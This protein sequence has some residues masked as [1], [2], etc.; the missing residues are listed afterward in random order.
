FYSRA[1][2][3]PDWGAFAAGIIKEI[4]F[5]KD[6]FNEP[7]PGGCAACPPRKGGGRRDFVAFRSCAN[8]IGEANAPAL[9]GGAGGTAAGG[10]LVVPTIFFGGGTPSLMPIQTFAEIISAARRAFSIAPDAEITIEANPGTITREKLCEFIAA[11]VNR[12]SIGVQS[13]RDEELNFLGRIHDA[14]A[15]RALIR[16][17]K[18]LGLRVSADFIYGL[19]GQGVRDIEEMCRE[20]NELDLE[21]ASLYELT[22]EKNSAFGKM[23][24]QVPD[25]ETA[26]RMYETIGA[27]LS[28][29]RYEV[30][31]YA[32]PGAE[33]R[34]NTNIWDGQPYIGFGPSAAGR[35]L[36]QNAKSGERSWCEQSYDKNSNLILNALS[37]KDRAVEKIITGLRTARGLALTQDIRDAI[38]WDFCKL[39]IS[40]GQLAIKDERLFA[41][42]FLT[43]DSIMLHLIK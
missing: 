8:I 31:N 19:P 28:L 42:D 40:N 15:A 18:S 6:K 33:C 27:A 38:D 2:T 13:L 9:A 1:C 32:R 21:H 16:E 43:L 35:I 34:H 25:N 20:I 5:W 24:L 14:C 10:G 30:S 36:E 39:A 11:G 23:N 41:R 3:N 4:E 26:A 12:I 7:T 22:I 29:P 37:H 17:A